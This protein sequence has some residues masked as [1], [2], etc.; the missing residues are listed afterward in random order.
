M[1]LA[2]ATTLTL[3]IAAT[4]GAV[5]AQ[6]QETEN[7]VTVTRSSMSLYPQPASPVVT[8]VQRACTQL[9]IG[10]RIPVDECGHH[11]LS[12]VASEYVDQT[13]AD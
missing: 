1:K 13:S 3:F 4:G 8:P 10:A 2:F 11:T 7:V 5:H 9:E 12:Y 6:V